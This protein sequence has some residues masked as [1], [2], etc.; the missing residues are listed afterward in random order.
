M[1]ARTAILL[2][3]LL[4]LSGCGST[5]SVP[6]ESPSNEP[7]PA[8][9]EIVQ[10]RVVVTFVG[11]VQWIN[12]LRAR[13]PVGLCVSFDPRF[14]LSVHVDSITEGPAPFESQTDVVLSIHSPARLF[15]ESQENVIGKTY[16]FRLRG[17]RTGTRTRFYSISAQR[18]QN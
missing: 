16:L 5:P 1:L 13:Q 6:P 10:E 9:Q 17:K 18:R 4:L 8:K 12:M 15:A 2:P 14:A 11:T 3:L 7:S